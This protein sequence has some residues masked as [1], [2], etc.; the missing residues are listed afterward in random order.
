ML[1]AG[2]AAAFGRRRGRGWRPARPLARFVGDRVNVVRQPEPVDALG[3]RDADAGLRDEVDGRA[4]PGGAAA[5]GGARAAAQVGDQL[6]V[7]PAAGR[8][9][10]RSSLGSAANAGG[11]VSASRSAS[12]C[13]RGYQADPI[14]PRTAR[15]RPCFCSSRTLNSL[16]KPST[17]A[18]C[19]RDSRSS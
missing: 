10:V 8:R 14:T 9:G 18:A 7:G 3:A 17:A 6:R 2:F 19:R 13:N 16:A 4:R 5:V 11:A 12:T 15:S 1:D